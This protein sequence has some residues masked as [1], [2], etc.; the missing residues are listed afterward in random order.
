MKK[1]TD[2]AKHMTFFFTS[3]LQMERNVSRNTIEAYRYT[4]ILF[5]RY[6]RD[7][8]NVKFEKLYL[9][10]LTR[11]NIL[12]FLDWLERE[13]KSSITTRNYRLAA[14]RSFV[15]YLQY[16]DVD[17]ALQ[18]QQILCI[19]TKKSARKP[20]SHLSV[21]GMKLLLSMP[22][23]TT[24]SGLR[25]V[26]LLSLIYDCGARVSEIINLTPSAL[27]LSSPPMCAALYGKGRK[28]RTVVLL[29][30]QVSILKRYMKVNHLFEDNMSY[31]PLFFNNKHEK[32]SR[33]GVAYILKKNIALARKINP[34]IIPKRFSLHGL[35][36]SKAMHLLESGWDMIQIRDFL[37]HSSVITTDVYARANSKLQ[38]VAI[39]RA[40]QNILPEHSTKKEWHNNDSFEELFNNLNIYVD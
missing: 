26:A 3:Y 1:P 8:K 31:H 19:K 40:Y 21:E 24:P 38:E 23:I 20:I 9:K 2:F 16:E 28:V 14:L 27:K 15:K 39:E 17:N 5:I 7:L 33:S 6:M 13:R 34:S 32:L 25:E 22:D 12:D 29:P 35:R 36:H 18:W 11:N 4:F 37:G 10:H 30:K